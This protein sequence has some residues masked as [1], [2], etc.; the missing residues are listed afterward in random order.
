MI[1]ATAAARSL[2]ERHRLAEAGG[3]VLAGELAAWLERTG[4]LDQ[5]ATIAFRTSAG[6]GERTIA[7]HLEHIYA[8]L[9]VPNRGAA[10]ALYRTRTRGA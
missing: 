9:G 5:L 8:K 6:V 10:L 4:Q 2:L 1:E 3:G 7:K